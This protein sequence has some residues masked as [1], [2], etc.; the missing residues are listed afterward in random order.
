MFGVQTLLRI[1]QG[2]HFIRSSIP[3]LQISTGDL[4][5]FFEHCEAVLEC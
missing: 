4:D 5:F 2:S 1:V 3:A